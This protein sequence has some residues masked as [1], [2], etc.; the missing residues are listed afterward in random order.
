MIM[1]NKVFTALVF[2]LGASS[3]TF[4]ITEYKPKETDKWEK[5]YNSY[6]KAINS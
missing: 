2:E 5:A 6:L 3:G 1:D 4:T